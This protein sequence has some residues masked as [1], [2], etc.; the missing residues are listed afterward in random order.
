[1][2]RLVVIVRVPVFAIRALPTDV[3]CFAGLAAKDARDLKNFSRTTR[4]V[5]LF[6]LTDGAQLREQPTLTVHVQSAWI[7][8][9]E[10]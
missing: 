3:A 7:V 5:H 4:I 8:P 1:M 6:R 2:E 10:S 9:D